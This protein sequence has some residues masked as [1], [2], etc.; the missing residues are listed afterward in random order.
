MTEQNTQESQQKPEGLDAIVSNPV[1]AAAAAIVT[2][3]VEQIKGLME[4][5][6]RVTLARAFIGID[7]EFRQEQFENAW[8]YLSEGYPVAMPESEANA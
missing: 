6:S 3:H 8:K 1:M 4:F 2:E 7:G 5:Q